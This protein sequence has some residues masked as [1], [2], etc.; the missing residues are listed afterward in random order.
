LEGR[1]VI[2]TSERVCGRQDTSVQLELGR[3]ADAPA[4]ARAAVS[5]LCE[6][7]GLSGARCHTLLLLVS[8]I[9]TNAVLHSNERPGAPIHFAAEAADGVLRIEVADGGRGFTDAD[10]TRTRGGW[11]LRLVAKEA[12][13]WGV[14]DAR[15]TRVWFELQLD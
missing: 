6:R 11:G 2:P 12:S 14:D 3:G 1:V 9:V 10:A 7:A 8:E 5:G 15:G 13:R 4:T